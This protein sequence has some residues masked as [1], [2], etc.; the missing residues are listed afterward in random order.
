MPFL[1]YTY[2]NHDNNIDIS[3]ISYFYSH[4][5][6]HLRSSSNVSVVYLHRLLQRPLR[7]SEQ[8]SLST[9]NPRLRLFTRKTS[10]CC[11]SRRTT[12][13]FVSSTDLWNIKY[14]QVIEFT[15]ISVRFNCLLPSLFFTVCTVTL[16][17]RPGFLVSHTPSAL[18]WCTFL[19]LA[20]SASE[21]GSWRREG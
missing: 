18:P 11:T 19:T 14:R 3:Y 15:C 17:R 6:W 1:K 21:L 8:S 4:E 5:S 9:E 7:T 10:R 16:K 13:R 12:T 2:N 20:H